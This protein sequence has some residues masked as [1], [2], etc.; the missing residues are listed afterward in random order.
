VRGAS[1]IAAATVLALIGFAANSVLCRKALGAHAIDAWS[2]TCVRLGSGALTL[3]VLVRVGALQAARRREREA[4]RDVAGSDRVASAAEPRTRDSWASAFALFAYAGAFSLA[5]LRLSAGVGA[6]VLFA[7]VQATMIGWGIKSGERPSRVE[8]LGIAVALAGLVLLTLPGAVAPDPPDTLGLVL[9]MSAGIAWGAYSLRGRSSR[10]PLRSTADN[11][12]RSVPMAVAG[13]LVGLSD[14]HTSWLGIA[15]AMASGSIASGLG[16]SLWYTALPGL[17]ATRAAI[18]QLV[19]PILAATL[20]ILL[21]G[22]QLTARLSFS[23]LMILGGVAL[24]I[25]G[26]RRVRP[27][28]AAPEIAPAAGARELTAES[29]SR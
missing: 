13:V 17:S 9:M 19:V 18:V 28:P 20:G 21:L 10:S 27:I 15:L 4:A 14:A 22:E 7:C 29:S 5:Y 23:A 2:F 12:A 24:A 26:R 16:Y 1:R 8:W 11:F 6:L 25:L 3:L